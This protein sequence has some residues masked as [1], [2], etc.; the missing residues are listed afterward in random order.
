MGEGKH[1]D[2]SDLTR[3]KVTIATHES[4]K[5]KFLSAIWDFVLLL[6]RECAFT[7]N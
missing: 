3:Q 4:D 1:K 2:K 7:Q 6:F 5:L